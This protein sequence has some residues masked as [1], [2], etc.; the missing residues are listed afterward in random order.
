MLVEFECPECHGSVYESNGRDG[1]DRLWRLLLWAEYLSP[2]AALYEL[3][4]GDRLPSRVYICKA[5]PVMVPDRSYVHCAHCNEFHSYRLW[6]GRSSLGNWFGYKCP[7]CGEFIQCTWSLTSQV[8]LTVTMPIWSVLTKQLRIKNQRQIEQKTNAITEPYST[9][10]VL[11]T[12][13]NYTL[14]IS[15]VMA[16]LCMFAFINH[17][18]CISESHFDLGALFCLVLVSSAFLFVAKVVMVTPKGSKSNYLCLKQFE[19]GLEIQNEEGIHPLLISRDS[20]TKKE[21]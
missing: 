13:L 10:C 2:I 18:G 6:S 15:S 4:L 21:F 8:I 5:C 7:T 16:L 17:L 1:S 12:T 19:T 11:R 3:V 9:H 14:A 20:I